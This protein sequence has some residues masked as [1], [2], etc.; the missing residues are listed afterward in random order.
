MENINPKLLFCHKEHYEFLKNHQKHNPILIENNFLDKLILKNDEKIYDFN[1]EKSTPACIYYSSGTTGNPKSVVFSHNNMI[2]NISS[3][4]RGFRF[5]NSETHMIILPLGHTASVNYSFL[6]CTLLGGTLVIYESFWKTRQN[7]WKNIK[8]F[9][10]TYIEVVPSVLVALLNTPYEKQ[11]FS[12][13]RKL[14]FIGCG[15]AP[16][17]IE[18]QNKIH[19]KF[20]FKVANLYGLSETGPTHIDY[21]LSENWKP[22]SIGKPLDV[23]E[24]TIVDENNNVLDH[25]EIG[26]IVITGRNV[27]IGYHNNK[28]IYNN[29]VID[30]SFHTGDLGYKNKDGIFFFT[31]RKK[32]LIIKGGINISPDEID[33]IIFKIDEIKEAA[34]VGIEDKFLGEKIISYIV[35]KDDKNISHEYIRNFCM[36]FLSK[37]KIPDVI[38]FVESLPK[39]PSGKILRKEI[40]K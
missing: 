2:S 22:G 28:E 4:C 35:L 29:V 13:I 31:G 16:L 8:E 1:P 3:I 14:K 19:E 30:G 9:D 7:F 23:N 11:T 32:E 6:P 39:G 17:P 36:K 20:G 38:K 27:F 24:V 5:K 37:E 10:I 15:S 40:I 25:D 26:E 21:P 33:E 18:L 34:T 12:D